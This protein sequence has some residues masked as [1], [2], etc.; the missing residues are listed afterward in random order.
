MKISKISIDQK[1]Y[2][3]QYDFNQLADCEDIAGCNLLSAVARQ[4]GNTALELRGVFYAFL[5]SHHPEL[6]IHDAARLIRAD[7]MVQVIDAIGEAFVAAASEEYQEAFR[8]AMADQNEEEE[9]KGEEE[10]PLLCPQWHDFVKG[11]NGS[12]LTCQLPGD[13]PCHAG[14]EK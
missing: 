11:K 5:H 1:E 9:G 3:L 13:H 7:T 4:G 6:T 2:R 10:R 12:C 8:K 14:A